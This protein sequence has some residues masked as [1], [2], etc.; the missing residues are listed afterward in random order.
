MDEAVEASHFGLFLNMGQV[1]T[2]G[3]R[4]FVHEDIYDVFLKKA[5]DRAEKRKVGNPFQDGV[6]SGPQ[7]KWTTKT[8]LFTNATLNN[9]NASIHQ[10]HH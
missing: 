1:C 9:H 10:C 2:A 7:V 8:Y 3:S 6:E 4:I 5:I